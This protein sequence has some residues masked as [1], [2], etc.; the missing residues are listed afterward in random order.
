MSPQYFRG[1]FIRPMLPR[2]KGSQRKKLVVGSVIT[3]SN[4]YCTAKNEFSAIALALP[5][6][7]VF[8]LRR[9]NFWI[10]LLI[11]Q[12]N[13]TLTNLC[14]LYTPTCSLM[15]KLTKCPS[16]VGYLYN[17]PLQTFY[18]YL[19]N[20]PKHFGQSNI[21]KCLS[22]LP[23]SCQKSSFLPIIRFQEALI[24]SPNYILY[25]LRPEK[26][27]AFV[28]LATESVSNLGNCIRITKL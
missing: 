12:V 20:S 19:S 2:D 21:H 16:P 5:A 4:W 7:P 18:Y 6:M 26:K 14:W 22:T 25:F 9:K 24:I 1:V 13:G 17:V 8:C 10:V 23:R 15:R 11:R 28:F 27:V 3:W